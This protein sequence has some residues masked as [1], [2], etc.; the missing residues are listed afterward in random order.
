VRDFRDE[1]CIPALL[2]K[3]MTEGKENLMKYKGTWHVEHVLL[4]KIEEWIR[5]QEESG[6]APRDWEVSTLDD[7]PWFKGWQEKW[8]R[9]QGF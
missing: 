4:P 5:E 8:H 9:Q 7:S 6:L 3:I 1:S 2:K